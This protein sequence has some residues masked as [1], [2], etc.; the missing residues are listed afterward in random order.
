MTGLDLHIEGGDLLSQDAIRSIV[1]ETYGGV[2]PTDRVDP[3]IYRVHGAGADPRD[4]ERRGLAQGRVDETTH[5]HLG[6]HAT[7]ARAAHAVGQGRDHA[8]S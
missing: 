1:R 3:A 7:A 6:G 5:G 8:G 4:A 2:G